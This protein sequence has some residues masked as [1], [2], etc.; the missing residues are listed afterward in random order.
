MGKFIVIEGVDG[1]GKTTVVEKI[2]SQQ[3]LYGKKVEVV[4]KKELITVSSTLT[5][6]EKQFYN[7]LTRLLWPR[8]LGLPGSL[9]DVEEIPVNT[10]GFLHSGW[11]NFIYEK[12]I[13]PKLESCDYLFVDGWWYKLLARIMVTSAEKK[14]YALGMA[15]FLPKGDVHFFFDLDLD[16]TWERRAGIF[17]KSEMGILCDQESYLANINN[18]YRQF[19]HFQPKVRQNMLDIIPA[20]SLEILPIDGLTTEEVISSMMEK[21]IAGIK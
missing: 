8:K 16:I 10:W 4:R 5:S 13:F 9:D 14:A 17:S 21:I 1:A 3:H 20:D 11:Y 12:I 6:Y 15:K 19:K 7:D 18:P 2:S